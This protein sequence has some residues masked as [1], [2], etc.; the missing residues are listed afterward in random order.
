MSLE[1][2]RIP[3]FRSRG[4]LFPFFLWFLVSPV[5]VPSYVLGVQ[6][7]PVSSA[8]EVVSLK[9]ICE[10]IPIYV[11]FFF[12]LYSLFLAMFPYSLLFFILLMIYLLY[13]SLVLSLNKL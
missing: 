1:F 12:F 9:L 13:S 4:I 10:V 11:F 2:S 8:Q 3:G 7:S 6:P 5:Y